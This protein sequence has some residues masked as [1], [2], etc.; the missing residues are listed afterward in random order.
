MFS[1]MGPPLPLCMWEKV[2]MEKAV[3]FKSKDD[4]N[5]LLCHQYSEKRKSMF[6]PWLYLNC[7]LDQK[8]GYLLRNQDA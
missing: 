2:G 8:V 3:C 5:E 6:H 7:Y 1:A 4:H